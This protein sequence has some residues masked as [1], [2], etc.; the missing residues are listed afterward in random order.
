MIRNVQKVAKRISGFRSG[1]MGMICVAI[2]L[3][4]FGVRFPGLDV[5]PALQADEG[6][7]TIG[8]KNVILH[9]DWFLDSRTHLFLSPFFHLISA[10][11][12]AV[13]GPGITVARM[14]SAA[15]GVATVIC[16]G[17]LVHR[18]NRDALL[19]LT[20]MAVAAVTEFSVLVSRTA[21][22]ESLQVLLLTLTG[23]FLVSGRSWNR[24]VALAVVVALVLLTKLNS[25]F[26]LLV[27]AAVVAHR[28]WKESSWEE[29]G[30]ALP[31]LVGT[32]LAVGVYAILYFWRP[33]YFQSAFAFEL[34]G[35]HFLSAGDPLIRFGRFGIVPGKIAESVIGLFREMPF[36]MTLGAIGFACGL[37]ERFRE[38]RLFATWL[39][40]GMA[41]MLIQMFQ[42]IRYFYLVFPPLVYFASY[43]IV[44][45]VRNGERIE[46]IKRLKI[47]KTKWLTVMAVFLMFELAYIGGGLLTNRDNKLAAVRAA[48]TRLPSQ[49][50]IVGASYLCVD[51]RQKCLSHYSVIRSQR[52]VPEAL[53][54]SGADYVL[55]DQSEW[56]PEARSAV[57][58]AFT[59]II[60][61][62]FGGVYRV[63][64]E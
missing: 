46:G 44:R 21:L 6:L 41:F 49:S 63:L 8:A 28:A 15:A 19:T 11:L 24:A 16:L 4:A 61:F 54:R 22:I 5:W 36:V 60:E 27:A 9:D 25:G 62:S 59:K 57:D 12:F 38:G 31:I 53:I 17:L 34:E 14:I 20:A 39:V 1:Q 32:V 48:S 45:V 42:P 33:L 56:P 29:L 52:D 58:D 37:S 2:V 26:I 23:V 40:F 51:V 64:G 7:W 18:I 35:A 47:Q 43:A 50:T 55:I 3:V 30:A 13:A 10:S